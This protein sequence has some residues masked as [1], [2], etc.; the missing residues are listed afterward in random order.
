MRSYRFWQVVSESNEQRAEIQSYRSLVSE[1]LQ[2]FRWK[3]NSEHSEG[4]LCWSLSE[5]DGKNEKVVSSV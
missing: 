5:S 2:S 3:F 1:G 4:D